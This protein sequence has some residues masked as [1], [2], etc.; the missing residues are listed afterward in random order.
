MSDSG[1]NNDKILDEA[2]VEDFATALR[3]ARS[4]GRQI[5]PIVGAGLSADS[6]FPVIMAIVR[7]FGKLARYIDCKVPLP[8]TSNDPDDPL[9]CPKIAWLEQLFDDYTKE[10]W[11]FIE[12]FGWPDRFQLNQDLFTKLEKDLRNTNPQARSDR[13]VEDAVRAGIER[14]LPNVNPQGHKSYK[15]LREFITLTLENKEGVEA[16]LDRLENTWGKSTA[17]DLVGDWRRLILSF[18]NYQSD[19]AD[20]LF[21]R[22]G[23]ARLPGHGHRFLSFL[24]KT[25]AVPTVFTFNFDSLIEQAMELAGIKPRVFAMERGAGL[26]HA[27]MVRDQLSVVKM[28]GSTHALLLDEQLDRPLTPDYIRRFARITGD[29]PLLLVIG[30]SDGDRRL[31]D[32]VGDVLTRSSQGEPAVLWLHY[33]K[34]PPPFL[35]KLS[36]SGKILACPTNNPGATLQHLHSWLTSYNPAGRVPYLAHIEQPIYRGQTG[37]ESYPKKVGFELFS[38][39]PTKNPI[40]SA[41]HELLKQANAW[42]RN[43]YHFIWTDL[44]ASHTFAGVVGSI[45]DQCRK[46][47]P[48]VAPSVLP[49]DID[50][51][52][53]TSP[54]QTEDQNEEFRKAT[55]KLAAQR[56]ARALRRTRYY[57]ALDALEA[58]VWPATTHHGLTH[59]AVGKGAK[60]RLENLVDFLLQ[61]SEEQLGESVIGIS[62]DDPQSRHIEKL[63]QYVPLQVLVDKLKERATLAAFEPKAFDFEEKFSDLGKDLPLFSYKAVPAE[64]ADL[65]GIDDSQ[66]KARLGLVLFT[67]SCFRRIRPLAAMRDLLAPLLGGTDD[68]WNEA[69]DELLGRITQRE[70]G[71]FLKQLEGGGYWF[72]RTIRNEVYAQNT[73]YC[74]TDHLRKCMPRP[75][76]KEW[77]QPIED[78]VEHCRNAAFQL[79]LS[80]VIHQN[81]TRTLYTRTFIQAQDTFVFMEYSYHRLSSIRSLAKLRRLMT[82]GSQKEAIAAA[83]MEGIAKCGELI[84]LIEPK[85]QL[86][87]QL[88]FET[89]PPFDEVLNGTH[90]T[91]ESLTIVGG[92]EKKLEDRHRREVDS[93]YR[94]WTRADATLRTQIPAEQLLHWCNELLTDDLVHRSN[95]VVIDYTDRR[96]PGEQTPDSQPQYEPEYDFHGTGEHPD[97]VDP[98]LEKGTIKNFREY[99]QDLQ[100]KLWIERSDYKVGIRHR[101]R[102]LIDELRDEHPHLR[103]YGSSGPV[104]E[105]HVEELL[106]NDDGLIG[107]CGILQLQRLLDVVSCELQFSQESTFGDAAL[108]QELKE[109]EALLKRIEKRLGKCREAKKTQ[110]GELSSPRTRLVE[111]NQWNEAWL[112]LIHL[113]AEIQLGHVSMFSHDSFS[114]NPEKWAPEAASWRAAEETIDYGL[115]TNRAEDARTTDAPRSV[116]LDPATN[117]A[118]YVQYRSVF[119]M[120]KGRTVWLR[121]VEH[122]ADAFRKAGWYFEMARGGLGDQNRLVSALI[123][124]YAVE[125]MLAEARFVMISAKKED[126]SV[127][128]CDL[129]RALY[130]SA[131]GCLQRAQESLLASRRN[132]IWRKFFYR[133][134]TQYHAD[135]LFLGYALLVKGTAEEELLEPDQLKAEAGHRQRKKIDLIRE[136]VLRLRRAYQ[137]LL[138]AVDLYM[139]QSPEESREY[140]NNFRWLYRMWWELTLCGYA[141]GRVV[142]ENKFDEKTADRYLTCQLR[143]LNELCGINESQLG[144]IIACNKE[145]KDESKF[146]RLKPE[147]DDIPV[148]TNS[149]VMGALERR[150]SLMQQARKGAEPVRSPQ[151]Q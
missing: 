107:I 124:L 71:T 148:P 39:L 144:S 116:I 105:H 129:A 146:E 50:H 106:N 122:R 136:F 14:V 89:K 18:T 115:T 121:D 15:D 7:Y 3:T 112:R 53:T 34:K 142:L 11:E 140:P 131:R 67:L 128:A 99:L 62:V 130:D 60:Q 20:A 22:F 104:D 113:K 27:R 80:A 48:D 70:G 87:R 86:F 1:S 120:L 46:Y 91:A 55:I 45:I 93:L 9:Y 10:P 83:V 90:K 118:L 5:V 84:R 94:A 65:L 31:R 109:P 139:P 33:E 114:G 61:L 88:M 119:H 103:K 8:P 16:V 28:H 2:T 32:L 63:R 102:H 19:D 127:K 135:R 110:T 69:V 47:D 100:V 13:I 72:T 138:T 30:C 76:D 58:Y 54:A 141:T 82:V 143:W 81:I 52:I 12:A 23:A 151:D 147:Y 37:E 125:A 77:N 73:R 96:P 43:G 25:L 38:S 36:G 64:L 78:R 108:R 145:G 41:S 85:G 132:V 74:D 21:A 137:S 56:V 95:R 126:D 42:I 123:E 79:F 98:H 26:P 17:F 134:T 111:D 68:K 57:L 6:G 133:L 4:T 35:T 59:M 150:L 97:Q 75:K 92:M 44:E 149:G 40:P 101:L 66:R 51:P 49:V 117:G 29:N 24:I